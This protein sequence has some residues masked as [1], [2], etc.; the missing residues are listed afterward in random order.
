M[1]RLGF[2]VLGFRVLGCSSVCSVGGV[3]MYTSPEY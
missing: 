1:E 2:R 3:D